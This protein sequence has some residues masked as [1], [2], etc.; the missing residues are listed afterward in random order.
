MDQT[1]IGNHQISISPF[2][3]DLLDQVIKIELASRPS[4]WSRAQFLS[5]I[6]AGNRAYA[7]W[8]DGALIGY[9]VVWLIADELHIQN[10]VIA[11][12]WRK[13]GL[14][15]WL[16]LHLL[17]EGIE[18]RAE[19]VLLD[20]RSSNQAAISLYQKYQFERVGARK[21]YYRHGEDALL[22]TLDASAPAYRSFLAE[23]KSILAEQIRVRL[24]SETGV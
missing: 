1:E 6:Q 14:G 8:L 10:I 16:L 23:R 17:R 5:D 19:L 21:N 15:E 3:E 24:E 18:Q 20:V 2:V 7:L 11:P 9:A 4:P 22:M 12:T 13:R